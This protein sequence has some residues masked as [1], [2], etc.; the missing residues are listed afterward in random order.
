MT[1]QPADYTVEQEVVFTSRQS[2]WESN[3]ETAVNIASGFIVSYLVWMYII[4]VFWP[5]Y[6][7]S[8]TTAFWVVTLF[9][10]TSYLRSL[11]W[12]RFFNAE[13]HKVIH[14]LVKRLYA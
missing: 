12:R 11:T 14:K 10:V 6:S 4:P 3:I 1:E 7:S 5:E 8:H 13:L 2:F 9:T